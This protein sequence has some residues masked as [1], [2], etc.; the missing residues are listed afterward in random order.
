MTMLVNGRVPK[1]ELRGGRSA[2]SRAL[3]DDICARDI[4]A[5]PGPA[6]HFAQMESAWREEH[7]ATTRSLG[8]PD[9][10]VHCGAVVN[11]IVG[12]CAVGGHVIPHPRCRRDAALSVLVT[13]VRE[14]DDRCLR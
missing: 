14:V 5:A 3:E 8:C 10:R 12:H 2:R 6:L 11:V 4:D 13:S 9:G 7:N 1:E